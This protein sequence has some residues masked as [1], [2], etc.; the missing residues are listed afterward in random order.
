M[1]VVGEIE[2]VDYVIGS[3]IEEVVV[4]G[5]AADMGVWGFESDNTVV[6]GEASMR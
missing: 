6:L 2:D 3:G 4:D 1:G 5:K